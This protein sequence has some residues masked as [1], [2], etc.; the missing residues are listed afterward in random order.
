MT[1]PG[2]FDEAE[3]A[4]SIFNRPAY[5]LTIIFIAIFLAEAV[6]MIILQLLPPLEEH[7]DVLLDAL[8]LVIMYKDFIRYKPEIS[9]EF[10]MLFLIGILLA[11]NLI[12]AHIR[13]Y[14]LEGFTKW[15]GNL[16]NTSKYDV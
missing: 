6:I 15:I 7:Q 11:G 1:I 5:L 8:L 16:K 14:V 4:T 10:K 12:I 13:Y 9:K 3:C 2:K